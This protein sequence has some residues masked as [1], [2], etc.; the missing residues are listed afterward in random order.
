MALD[1]L[2]S[3]PE[4]SADRT[5]LFAFPPSSAESV[6]APPDTRQVERMSET[7]TDVPRTSELRATFLLF[8]LVLLLPTLLG[9]ALFG[10]R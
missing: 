2:R 1:L 5:A 8:A 6:L 3:A 9:C 7:A 10:M 4:I